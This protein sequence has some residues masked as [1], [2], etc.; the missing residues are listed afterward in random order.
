MLAVKNFGS[1]SWFWEIE[2]GFGEVENEIKL[3]FSINFVK[4]FLQK[5]QFSS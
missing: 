5:H 2:N 1:F 3:E 4:A